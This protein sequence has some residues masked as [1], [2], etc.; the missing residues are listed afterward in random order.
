MKT[1]RIQPLSS[2]S[3]RLRDSRQTRHPYIENTSFAK[4]PFSVAVCHVQ[5]RGHGNG[6]DCVLASA[7]LIANPQIYHHTTP[8]Q[9][10]NSQAQPTVSVSMQNSLQGLILFWRTSGQSNHTRLSPKESDKS[11]KTS[12]RRQ[13]CCLFSS[14]MMERLMN[15][16]SAP[17]DALHHAS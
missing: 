15:I 8:P 11:G 9:D 3:P 14:L 1:R 16:A 5:R 7:T 10:E 2:A 4:S 13:I 6:A 17:L 12:V